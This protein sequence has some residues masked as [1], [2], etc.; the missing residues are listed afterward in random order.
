[1]IIFNK[2][3]PYQKYLTIHKRLFNDPKLRFFL[4]LFK[5][6]DQ[7]HWYTIF[8]FHFQTSFTL[9]YRYRMK[10]L[11]CIFFLNLF[12]HQKICCISCQMYK[13]VHTL[14]QTHIWINVFYLQTNILFKLQTHTFLFK[15]LKH[16]SD[17]F[18]ILME[19]KKKKVF[20][21]ISFSSFFMGFISLIRFRSRFSENFFLKEIRELLF[22]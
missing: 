19:L 1:M 9:F 17:G 11:F 12:E 3:Y 21:W 16:T 6:L 7:H 13:C 22:Q 20:E 5:L 2:M 14:S 4:M 10:L 15:V 8:I 18:N